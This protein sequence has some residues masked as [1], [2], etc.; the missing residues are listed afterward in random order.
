MLDEKIVP[1]QRIHQGDLIVFLNETNPLRK[2]GLV[3]TADC[4]LEKK[5]HGR[6]V[7]LV[8]I[9]SVEAIL[10][11]YLLIEACEKQKDNILSFLKKEFS[12]SAEFEESLLIEKI[13]MEIEKDRN[14]PQ[15]E[16]REI[17]E[18]F[19]SHSLGCIKISQY[20]K[21]MSALRISI[22]NIRNKVEEQIKGK[23][24]LILLPTP[25]ELGV[26]GEIVWVRHMWQVPVGKIVFR[27]SDLKEDFGQKVARLDSPFRY[28]VTQVMGQVF[29]D[30]GLPNYEYTFP[31]DI[32]VAFK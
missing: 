31:A 25:L 28:R 11:N 16:V 15:F 22:D 3:V 19:I 6:L 18:K 2:A 20:K 4:D 8:P 24:D 30:I 32:G 13:R 27:N 23:G 12:I 26:Q 10:E 29:S 14:S 21:L 7:T 5:K 9:V 1:N 17:A